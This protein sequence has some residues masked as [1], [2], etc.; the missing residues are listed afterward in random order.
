MQSQSFWNTG[1]FAKNQIQDKFYF[2]WLIAEIFLM[3][4]WGSRR[5]HSHLAA[6][7][8]FITLC[9]SFRPGTVFAVRNC[10]K[11]CSSS[12]HSFFVHGTLFLF[13]GARLFLFS[14]WSSSSSSSTDSSSSSNMKGSSESDTSILLGCKSGSSAATSASTTSLASWGWTTS[15]RHKISITYK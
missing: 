3:I 7:I 12:M 2:L 5:T 1:F 15:E 14:V 10:P 11:N 8:S 9:T 6:F 13:C 4:R